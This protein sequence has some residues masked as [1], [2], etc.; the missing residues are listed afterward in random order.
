MSGKK[1]SWGL[2]LFLC[3]CLVACQMENPSDTQSTSSE[4]ESLSLVLNDYLKETGGET[5]VSL[6]GD[7]NTIVTA[8]AG[9]TILGGNG[10]TKIVLDGGAQGAG[11]TA[12]GAGISV[13]QAIEG[14]TL[15]FKN[16]TLYDE[17][18]FSYDRTKGYLELGGDLRFVNCVITDSILLVQNVRA[19]FVNCTF[20]SPKTLRYSVWV[21]EGI[22]TFENCTFTG[23]RGLKIHEELG[24]DVQEVS[25]DG[26]LFDHIREK[27]GIAI[28][29]IDVNPLSTVISVTN[30]QFINCYAWDTVGSLDGVDGY[31][32]TDTNLDEFVF[33]S[34]DN[35]VQFDY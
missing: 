15:E 21:A 2:P 27:P 25:L 20:D 34:E 33:V 11:V 1:L 6:Q 10:A 17:T 18:T 26:C 30:S 8:S 5:V 23:Y 28:G 4:K 32:E 7:D 16:I 14:C 29:T 12:I 9:K 22:A 19:E 3:F 13:I 35:E 31:Y 24:R